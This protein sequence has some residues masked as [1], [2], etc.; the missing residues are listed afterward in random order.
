MQEQM[1]I[2]PEKEAT[3]VY[4]ASKAEN[5]IRELMERMALASGSANI[6][7][8][9]AADVVEEPDRVIILFDVPGIP[10]ERLKIVVGSN[11]V[12]VR[13]DPMPLPQSKFVHLERMANYRLQ[14]K[15][16]FP[17]KLKIDE[18]KAYLKDGV[19]QITI[20]KI[21]ENATE[22]ELTVE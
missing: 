3:I 13:T 16:E 7:R 8:E 5:A 4:D 1:Q 9:P 21:G 17:F 10:K 19:L 15:I 6:S 11:Y 22:T 14:R 2:P 20:P 18:A 12:E